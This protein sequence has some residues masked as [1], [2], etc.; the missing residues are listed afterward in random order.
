[1]AT[2]DSATNVLVPGTEYTVRRA[3]RAVQ[4]L[5]LWLYI[6]DHS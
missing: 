4:N 2:T 5:L 6:E 3:L 1:M